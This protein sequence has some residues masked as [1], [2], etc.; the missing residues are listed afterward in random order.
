MDNLDTD[1]KVVESQLVASDAMS[2]EELAAHKAKV[3]ARRKRAETLEGR[4][5]EA[6][7]FMGDLAFRFPNESH[8]LYDYYNS[9]EFLPDDTPH[10][11]MAREEM[12]PFALEFNR[13]G[14]V[15]CDDP[16]AN[17]RCWP[18]RSST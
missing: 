10:T 16:L 3:A 12:L 11:T 4:I 9:R 18:S 14:G 17:I 5:E 8:R 2:P 13:L 15:V 6:K 7:E 1:K